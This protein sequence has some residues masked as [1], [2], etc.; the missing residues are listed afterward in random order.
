VVS[1]FCKWF[2]NGDRRVDRLVRGQASIIGHK[3]SWSDDL[4][5]GGVATD[6]RLGSTGGPQPNPLTMPARRRL[7]ASIVDSLIVIAVG[8]AVSVVAPI[9]L[10]TSLAAFAVLYYGATLATMGCTPVTWAIEAYLDGR[11]P[12]VRKAARRP[13]ATH[14]LSRSEH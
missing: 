2:K 4:A 14:V 12:S 5:A 1:D 3:S 6:R 10:T 8:V 9:S 13:R 7:V 11:H